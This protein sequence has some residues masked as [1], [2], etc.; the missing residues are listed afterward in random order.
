[1]KN[2]ALVDLTGEYVQRPDYVTDEYLEVAQQ[3]KVAEEQIESY[4]KTLNSAIQMN[5]KVALNNDI[6]ALKEEIQLLKEKI[7]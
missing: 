7:K 4:R 2:Y 6:H 1:M 5:E 3:I